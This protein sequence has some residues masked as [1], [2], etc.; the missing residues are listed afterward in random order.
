MAQSEIN[1]H[2]IN[3]QVLILRK[4]RKLSEQLRPGLFVTVLFAFF[5]FVF[6]VIIQ[7]FYCNWLL[8][9]Y[10]AFKRDYQITGS[11][12]TRVVQKVLS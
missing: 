11:L 8:K 1:S 3:S 7:S 6:L 10:L 5:V 4:H 12:I 2:S 9:F